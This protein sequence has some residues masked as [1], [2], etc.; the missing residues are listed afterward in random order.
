MRI[1]DTVGRHR[2]PILVLTSLLVAVGAGAAWRMP[3][4]I[5]PEIGFHRITV[6][7]HAGELPVEQ[8]LTTVTQPL[9][10][11][12][13]AVPG[14]ARIRSRTSRGGVEVDLT[15]DW[16]T[17][18]LPTLQR[19]Q[20]A[21]EEVR[22]D[23]PTGTTMEARLLD[24]SAFPIIGVAVSSDRRSLADVSDFVIYEA[25]P[26]LR[27]LPGVYRVELGGAKIREW[28]LTVDPDALVQRRLSLQAV[29]DAVRAANVVSAGGEIRDDHQLV[30]AV[31]EGEGTDLARLPDVIV[32][33]DGGVPVR[34]RDVARIEATVEEDFV[35]TAADGRPAVLIGVSRQPDGDTIAIADG[36]RAR[37][38]DLERTHPDMRFTV[39]YDQSDLVR[40]AIRSVRDSIALG[41]LLAV[42]TILLFIADVRTTLVAAA[43]IPAAVAIACIGLAA[44][45]MTFNLMTL[46]GIAASIGLVLDD[47]IV[48]IEN[49]H[50]HRALHAA[51]TAADGDPISE[52][53]HA[54][55]GSTLTPVAV[56]APV[57]L[58]SAVPGAFFRPLAATMSLALLVS[59][60]LALTFTPALATLAER[61]ASRAA[62]PGPGDRLA[63]A[64]AGA[65]VGTLRWVLDRAWLTLVVVPAVALCGW[66][67]YRHVATGFV[68]EMDEGAF[69]LDY[70]APPGSSLEETQ[71]MLR[72]VDAVLAA[73]PG[74]VAFSRRTGAELGF[75]LTETNRGDYAVRLADHGRPPIGTMM[76]DVRAALAERAPGLRVEF[77]QI[78]QDM[79]GDLSDTP[80]PIEV[81]LFGP[82]WAALERTARA[83]QA[84]VAGVP[85]V[86]DTFDGVTALGPTLRIGVDA[87][88]ARRAGLDAAVIQATIETAVTGARVGR[89]VEGDRAIP[90]RVRYPDRFR[91]TPDALSGVALVAQ[92]RVAPLT[93]LATLATEPPSAQRTREDLRQVARVTG[94]LEGRD[95]GS[96]VAAV[97]SMLAGRLPLPP[98]VMIELGGLHASQQAAFRELAL[99]FL[100]SL[101]LV[102]ALLVVEFG[103]LAPAVAIVVGSSLAVS[104]S[105]VTLWATGVALNVSS[106]VGMIMVVG[107]V[108]KNGILL[109]DFAQRAV[110]RG[111]DLEPALLDAGR[112]RLRPIL[113]T[114]LAAAAGLAPLAAGVGA[115]AQMQQPLAIAILG[116]LSVS[117]LL[118]LVGVPLVYVL[119]AGGG[120]SGRRAG[121]TPSARSGPTPAI[122]AKHEPKEP[123]P[124]PS[125]RA[126]RN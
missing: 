15:Y 41:V 46:G 19:V 61:P 57:A 31:V 112:V 99:V 83:A 111:V 7:V 84:L 11:A 122:G 56:L 5:F 3:L 10:N 29:A 52:I 73:T 1:G 105:L 51:G 109:V 90:L 68:P 91:D 49:W 36:V 72:P 25:A 26:T 77:V 120:G 118:S 107:I 124:D 70:W 16:R 32:A 78:L 100:A 102:S 13:T 59:L 54:L 88:A 119:L 126:P 58:L 23:L 48:V 62:R 12:V 14:L 9:E 85:G 45:G 103:A 6:I 50:R 40:A 106:V 108:A 117:M 97:R 82:D 87:V 33:D 125:G 71:R 35:R 30:L 123:S 65:Y 64:L 101:A 27:T 92:G 22:P 37:V 89:V 69:V 24:T 75:F 116:G 55:V 121:E 95:L 63:D 96:A 93:E 43:V 44:A 53:A 80:E 17:D 34:L 113:M 4:A 94:R 42:G 39:Y 110:A 47:A 79:I 21:M 38:A 114:S 81:K 20:A 74:V 98:G 86:V 18:M 28:A 115:G 76:A 66:V 2:T 104:G 67:A 8:T 60:G